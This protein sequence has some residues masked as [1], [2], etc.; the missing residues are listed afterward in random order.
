MRIKLPT[1][2]TL[3]NFISI[4]WL[5]NLKDSSFIKSIK[6][7][8]RSNKVSNF[9]ITT[10]ASI[11]ILLFALIPTWFYF[12]IRF[13]IE[14]EGF[15]QEFALVTICMIVIGWLQAIM[16]IIAVGLIFH[17]ILDDSPY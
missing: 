8:G 1:N 12:G 5:K 9:I 14:P 4:Q 3:T 17:I 13:L 15:W 16:L 6:R 11:I 2:I 10:I 7:F